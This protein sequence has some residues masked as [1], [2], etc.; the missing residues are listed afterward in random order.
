[1]AGQ[2]GQAGRRERRMLARVK[3]WAILGLGT[4]LILLGILGLFLP[5]LQG[6]L[7]LLLGLLVLSYE[8]APAKRQ[9]DRLRGRFPAASERIDAI[10]RR[11]KARLTRRTAETAET[12][13]R[14]KS[15]AD[16]GGKHAGDDAGRGG[17]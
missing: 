5:V 17:A 7:L 12:D 15:A 8:W 16:R 10:E 9:L 14:P 11:I 1:M 3:R 2:A 4:V 6:I 13:R